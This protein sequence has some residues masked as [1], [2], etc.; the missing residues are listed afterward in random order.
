MTSPVAVRD[1][2]LAD[3]DAVLDLTQRAHRHHT[4][5]AHPLTAAR[6]RATWEAPSRVP[7]RDTPV[8]VLDGTIVACADVYAREPFSEI[9][10]V[11]VVDPAID[12]ATRQRCAAL[13][14]GA[15]EEIGL[16]RTAHLPAD[17]A[18]LLAID[19]LRGDDVLA[20]AYDDLGLVAAR[21]EYEMV[22]DL[23]DAAMTEPRWP[24]GVDVRPIHAPADL[25]V[26]AEVLTESFA[27]HPG[28]LPFTPD[29]LDYVFT[30][31][32]V[33]GDASALVH[34]AHGPV[35]VIVCRD[36]ADHGYVWVVGVLARGRRQGL[37]QALLRRAFRSFADSGT[38][39]VTLDAE[40]QNVTGAIRVYE[41]VGMRVR[42]I[43]DTWTRPL[44]PAA[45]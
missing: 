4:G 23:R 3:L 29:F 38:A 31:A 20:A 40:A 15:A 2:T 13:L 24:H 16:E 7:G 10:A 18:R 37:A 5:R 27:D 34:D 39:L 35:G 8:V 45:S 32:D 21:Q 12:D 1:S 44:A 43:H 33:R 17:P 6:L 11:A 41:R 42:T 26:V 25:P 36:R 19:C 30:G 28:D 14:V 22:I 9:L